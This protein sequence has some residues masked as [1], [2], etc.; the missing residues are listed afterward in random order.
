MEKNG[1]YK[2][3]ERWLIKY[4]KNSVKSSSYIRFMNALRLIGRYKIANMIPSRI[5]TDDLQVFI[6]SLVSDKYSK[7]TIR[8][9]FQMF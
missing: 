9:T 2:E 1:L 4:K 5:T 8:K 6:N 7:E 3:I